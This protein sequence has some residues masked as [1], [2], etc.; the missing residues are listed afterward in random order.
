MDTQ[1]HVG[2]ESGV[3]S[4]R[5]R[6]GQRLRA[7]RKRRGV[8]QELLAKQAGL[9]RTYVSK[10]ERGERN[11]TLSTVDK[12]ASALGMRAEDLMCGK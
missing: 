2:V 1:S 3:Q 4:L 12:L 7:A 11:I 10:I 5:V 6:F 9:D 8:S